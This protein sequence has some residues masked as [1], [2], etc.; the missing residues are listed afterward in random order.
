MLL[1]ASGSGRDSTD[2]LSDSSLQTP[3]SMDNSPAQA[4]SP[5]VKVFFLPSCVPH[6]KLHRHK[7]QEQLVLFRL[8]SPSVRAIPTLA[9]SSGSC[10]PPPRTRLTAGFLPDRSSTLH[11]TST[12]MPAAFE[13]GAGCFH[14]RRAHGSPNSWIRTTPAA[15]SLLHSDPGSLGLNTGEDGKLP[16]SQRH[17]SRSLPTTAPCL[18]PGKVF[19][20]QFRFTLWDYGDRSHFPNIL[21]ETEI[22]STTRK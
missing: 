13:L 21:P 16:I 4:L 2:L 8:R 1:Q 9:Y 20:C 18:P 15:A 14:P 10:L 6:A 17:V 22:T 19:S 11:L 12:T 7:F 5:G 3:E